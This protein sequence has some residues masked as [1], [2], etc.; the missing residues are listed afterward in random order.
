MAPGESLMGAP[1]H[2]ASFLS[3]AAASVGKW[4]MAAAFLLAAMDAALLL[5]N[6]ALKTQLRSPGHLLQPP[7]GR[8]MPNL[9][10]F[11]P[12]GE[13]V[14]VNYNGGQRATLIFVFARGCGYCTQA[15][16]EWRDILHDL[17]PRGIK[18]VFISTTSG[19]SRAYADALGIGTASLIT[20]LDANDVV[21]LNVKLTPEIYEVDATGVL[22]NAWV[23]ALGEQG[24]VSIQRA[25]SAFPATGR[26]ASQQALPQPAAA[27]SLS[28]AKP[29]PPRS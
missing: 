22:R 16:Q 23:G 17:A 7:I 8:Q 13:L 10:G 9:Q 12:N 20:E 24:M 11:G 28:N 29:K 26:P 6:S 27:G 3:T 4:A 2:S 5:Q 15:W 18:P 21:A 25:L 1:T 19:V 14:T